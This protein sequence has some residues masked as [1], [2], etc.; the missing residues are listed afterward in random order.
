MAM[1]TPVEES[2][3]RSAPR[4]EEDRP[5]RGRRAAVAVLVLL[6]IQFVSVSAWQAWRDSPTVDEPV[7]IATGLAA[8]REREVRLNIE[9]PVFP[10]AVNALPLLVADIPLPLD[11]MWSEVTKL[12]P[13][14]LTGF[15]WAAFTNEFESMHLERDDYQRVVFLGRIMPI[16]Q[17]ALIGVVLFALGSALFGRSAGLL[18]GALWL[19]TPV[20]VGFSH[21]NSLDLAFTLAVLAACLALERHVRRPTTITLAWLAVACGLVMLVRYTGVLIVGAIAVG[22]LLA[23]RAGRSR[24]AAVADVAV[25]VVAAWAVVWVGTLA[26]APGSGSIPYPTRTVGS[27]PLMRTASRV[28]DVIPWPKSYELG[29]QFQIAASPLESPAY[30]MGQSWRGVRWWFW[31][32]TLAVKLPLAALAVAV[33]GPIAWFRLDRAT[34]RRAATVLLPSV[35]VLVVFLL[36]FPKEV[37]I[38]YALPVVAL[39]LVVGSP[40]A[41]WLVASRP[42]WVLAALLLVAQLASFWDAVPHSLAW[43]APP[44]RPGYAVAAESSLDWGQENRALVEWMD[45]RTVFVAPFGGSLEAVHKAPGYRQLLG[46]APG[47]LR[48]LAAASV[49]E[50]TTYQR[51]QLSWLRA[52][53][54]VGT[55]GG[56]ILLYRFEQPPTPE[57]GPSRPAGR[58]SGDVSVRTE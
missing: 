28:I 6:T 9:A 8:L 32:V 31:P 46:T 39:L 47:D 29:F 42:R 51:E 58:C 30:L 34:I 3:T 27:G 52:Y 14:E 4:A 45:G 20:A 16:V 19:T 53:C 43:T 2:L 12:E 54:H 36:P 1:A 13:D 18:A 38:R 17:G 50:L 24:W 49:T 5:D 55:I 25:I 21:L 41:P 11:G 40:V 37:G 10:K 26:V 7:H 15:E 57:P 23:P 33:L 56:S 48:G 35:V 44:F 22:L